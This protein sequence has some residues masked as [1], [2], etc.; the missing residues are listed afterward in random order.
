VTCRAKPLVHRGD[1]GNPQHL[2]TAQAGARNGP[3]IWPGSTRAR[4]AAPRN[5]G[6]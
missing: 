1:G 5:Y 3:G 4:S 6:C 2:A